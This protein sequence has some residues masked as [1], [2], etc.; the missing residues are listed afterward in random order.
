[1]GFT[2]AQVDKMSAWEFA[3]CAR[4]YSK[5]HGDGKSDAGQEMSE[6]QLRDLGIV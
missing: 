4:G 2:P 6:Q 3:A 1:M 5:A